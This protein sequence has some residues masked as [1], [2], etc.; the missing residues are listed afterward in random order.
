[1]PE[2]KIFFFIGTTAELIKI[3]PVIK[4]LKKR[5]ISF[6]LITSGQNKIHF[7]AF[8][9]FI[10]EIKPDISFKEK[11]NKSSVLYF[12]LWAARTLLV[13]LTSLRKEFKNLNKSNCYF[14]VHGDTVS[15]SIGA[16]T[17][18]FFNLRLVHIESGDLSFSLLEPFPEELCR[19]INIHLADIL[20]P[21]NEWAKNNLS[22]MKG[23]KI[24]TGQ[25]TLIET[26]WW[27]LKRKPSNNYKAFKKYYV[28]FM[29]RQ[30]HVI[31]RKGWA[32]KT[33]RFV[34]K[35]A[36]ENLNCLLI[37]HPL[38]IKIIHS[39]EISSNIKLSKKIKIISPLPY[40]D[41]LKLMENA[42]FIA[43]DG[44]SL[45]LETYLMG[46][47]CLI[48]RDLTEQ[49]EGISQNIVLSK[50][51]DEIIRNFLKNYQQYKTKPIHIDKRPSE[52]I[53]DYLMS[54]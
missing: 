29:H 49:V 27:A 32:K 3:A 2:K 28:L 43:T 5:N 6:K 52:I 17:A 31:F 44:A 1:M 33:M 37:N 23:T 7:E 9:D 4:E 22:S 45:Q 39:L 40:S 21:P 36:N 15:S 26:F 12:I 14:I 54:Q 35:N 41:F 38:T 42:E 46:K 16:V 11:V 34:I 20:F 24:T 47:P 50:G 19:N 30:E 48:L 8:T 13:S 10:G 51:N 25:N 53:V 18:K